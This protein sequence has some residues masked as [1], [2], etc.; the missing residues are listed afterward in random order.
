MQQQQE[1]QDQTDQTPL[2]IH[3][4]AEPSTSTHQW[5]SLHP[6]TPFFDLQEEV[7]PEEAAADSQ[8]EGVEEIQGGTCPNKE[9]LKEDHQETDS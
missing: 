3:G 4:S 1:R 8:E 7:H 2:L 9:I 6:D 5:D